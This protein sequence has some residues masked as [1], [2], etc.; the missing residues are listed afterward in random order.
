MFATLVNIIAADGLFVKRE[1]QKNGK[2]VKRMAGTRTDAVSGDLFIKNLS[3][4]PDELRLPAESKQYHG[5]FTMTAGNDAVK[6]AKSAKNTPSFVLQKRNRLG[7]ASHCRTA[8][9]MN[10]IG[11]G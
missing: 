2:N 3:C 10:E 5:L 8:I 1:M 4:E 11:K 7:Y 6:R 9:R